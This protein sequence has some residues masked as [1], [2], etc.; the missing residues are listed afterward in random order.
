MNTNTLTKLPVLS[1]YFCLLKRN[2]M[3]YNKQVWIFLIA[4]T[5]LG[6]GSKA[7][8]EPPIMTSTISRQSCNADVAFNGEWRLVNITEAS[9][10]IKP[11]DAETLSIA[12][13][14]TLERHLNGQ[15]VSKDEVRLFKMTNY[16]ADY[17]LVY[18]ND[19]IA[20]I[21]I[22]K[23]TLIVSECSDFEARRYFYKRVAG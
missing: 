23:D 7:G 1:F 4:I 11:K 5:S 17:Q 18:K 2:N 16:C 21:N 3:G 8:K 14:N 10:N 15:L 19:S 20:C 13:C 9:K 6:C 12:N 22:V